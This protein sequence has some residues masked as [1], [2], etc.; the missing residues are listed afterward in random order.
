M[1]LYCTFVVYRPNSIRLQD[2]IF[3]IRGG[4]KNSRFRGPL[5]G[6]RSVFPSRRN[7]NF[8]CT[9]EISLFGFDMIIFIALDFDTVRQTYNPSWF[10]ALFPRPYV[11]QQCLAFAFIHSDFTIP[12]YIRPFLSLTTQ[13]VHTQLL[14]Y[15]STKLSP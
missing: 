8:Q 9:R 12:F 4:R 10:G 13:R 2:V 7:L 5:N 6:E 1:W 15:A 14:K 3:H 11:K